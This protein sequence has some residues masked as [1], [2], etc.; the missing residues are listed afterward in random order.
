M[1][2]CVSEISLIQRLR[3]LCSWMGN[4]WNIQR[5]DRDAWLWL[6]TAA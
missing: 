2:D 6:Y 4:G 1:R 3:W 5:K